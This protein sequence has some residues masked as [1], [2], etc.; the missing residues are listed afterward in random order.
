MRRRSG[1]PTYRTDSTSLTKAAGIGIAV[2]LAIGVIWGYI[3]NWNFYLALLLGFSVAESMARIAGGKRGR[4]L[5][6]VGIAAILLGL[7]VS[8][9]VIAQRLGIT[10]E[11]VNQFGP[12]V[13][14][15]L[16]LRP[17]PDGLFAAMSVAIVWYRFR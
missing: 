2:A 8:R 4:D 5:Q 14:D 16:Y 15:Q 9:V 13:E 6:A 12:Y 3:P 7:L 1:L 17:I 10:W 11:Q